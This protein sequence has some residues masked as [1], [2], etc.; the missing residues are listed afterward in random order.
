MLVPAS[1]SSIVAYSVYSMVFGW[2][3]ILLEPT[4]ISFNNPLELLPYL[5]LAIILAL[6]A[7][8]Y[9][10]VFYGIQNFFK[11]LKIKNYLKPAIGGLLTGAIALVLIT[12]TGDK[13]IRCRCTWWWLWGAT[14]SN[15][16]RKPAH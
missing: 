3:H 5:V 2:E 12:S 16:L 7:N 6:A 10:K 1:V 8:A 14:G 15:Y 11:N 9:V 4:N 13:K